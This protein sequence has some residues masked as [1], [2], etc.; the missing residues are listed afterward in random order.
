MPDIQNIKY[1]EGAHDH[2]ERVNMEPDAIGRT[3]SCMAGMSVR[4]YQFHA[5]HC[6]ATGQ[7]DA[8][9]PPG[10]ATRRGWHVVQAHQFRR[11]FM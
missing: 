4:P 7:K 10:V 6:Y 3:L 2:P 11:D 8:P 5:R 9:S 1:L